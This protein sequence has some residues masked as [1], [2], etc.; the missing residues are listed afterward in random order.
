[1]DHS[2]KPRLFELA[3]LVHMH[4]CKI[5]MQFSLGFGHQTSTRD[6]WPDPTADPIA[7]SAVGFKLLPSG[8]PRKADAWHKKRGTEFK[9]SQ[10][11]GLMP[12]EATIE[13]IEEIEDTQAEGALALKAL[14]YD[15]MEIHC[16]HNYFGAGFLSPRIN[17]RTDKFS[18]NRV[19]DSFMSEAGLRASRA[20]L[21]Y[22][23][24]PVN[25]PQAALVKGCRSMALCCS[26][27]ISRCCAKRKRRESFVRLLIK[28]NSCPHR[29]SELMA[30]QKG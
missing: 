13:E 3:E 8:Q 25:M 26:F 7:A 19:A 28:N 29:L 24:L 5:F 27:P 20:M 2:A 30:A 22:L 1:M 10:A 15:G 17:R 18:R 23:W 11:E 12:R 6:Q 14:G 9:V 4:G 21:V 16:G